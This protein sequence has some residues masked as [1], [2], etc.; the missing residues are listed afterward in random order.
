MFKSM[1]LNALCLHVFNN[2]PIRMLSFDASGSVLG[3]VDRNAL[4]G[5]FVAIAL[6]EARRPEFEGEWRQAAESISRGYDFA[7]S[8]HDKQKSMINELIKYHTRYAILSHTWLRD[9]PGEVTYPGWAT[10]ENN[11]RGYT[12]IA[13]FCEVAAKEYGMTLG[14][15]D[16]V[17]IDKESSS[18][19]DESIRS[20]YKWYRG[21]HV[22][23]AYLARTRFLEGMSIDP[24]FTRGWTLQELL[25]PNYI[26]FYNQE[27]KDLVWGDKDI[28]VAPTI[29]SGIYSATSLTE[30]EME[31][32]R[33]GQ[34]DK[35]PISRMLQLASR[36]EV[37]REEDSAYSLM[38]LL[39]VDIS[40]AYGEGSERAF[41]R[42]VREF[43]NTKKHVLDIFN[44]GYG[45]NHGLLPTSI[46]QYLGRS[47]V[48]DV[49][50]DK[51]V[52]PLDEWLPSDPIIYTHL[53]V[54][55]PLVLCP[56]MKTDANDS[57]MDFHKSY[58]CQGELY[59]SV[60]LYTS[61][62]QTTLYNQYNL[63]DA[64][65][66][67]KNI[68]SA[69]RSS[70]NDDS[71]NDASRIIVFG[72]LN[73]TNDGDNIMLPENCLCVAFNCRNNPLNIRQSD[74]IEIIP[75]N[76]AP[77]IQIKS[78]KNKDLVIPVN[79]LQKHGLQ[80]VTLYL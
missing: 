41:F 46:R 35:I 36:R 32:C 39:S 45:T 42:L 10:R 24:W 8:G 80:W 78:T 69:L 3:L 61:Y 54:R 53:G 13:K 34:T 70:P 20:M 55:V 48:F 33:R 17:C 68:F 18:E 60:P 58:A 67:S 30:D 76:K 50:D 43:L 66:W 65:M 27:W 59:G 19:L 21:A 7:Q 5:Q 79:K 16:N 49:P 75:T 6:G 44:R 71:S 1:V 23:I 72:I 29:A 11:P 26:R 73:F 28:I 64:R 9:S 74:P 63:L 62:G 40:V 31:L 37:T 51:T 56:A 22:C 4:L 52:A 2:I 14:W 25:A 12:K 47:T 15:V 77:V 57:P 38:G